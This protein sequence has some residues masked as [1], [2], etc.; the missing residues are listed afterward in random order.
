LSIVLGLEA[1][2]VFFIALTVYG[3]H[4]LAPALAFGGGVALVI[5]LA[6]ATR[7]VRYPWGIWAGWILQLVL[8][9]TGL[10]L[11]VLYIVALAFIAIWVF[12]FVRGR[13]IDRQNATRIAENPIP[14]Q[15]SAP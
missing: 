11:P 2:L 15:E 12:C 5:L 1:V 7:V 13:Q 4:A 14:E 6:L 3:L 9:A 8:L 10:L